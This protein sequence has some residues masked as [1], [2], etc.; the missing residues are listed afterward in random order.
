MR[1]ALITAALAATAIPAAP[2]Q[3]TTELICDSLPYWRAQYRTAQDEARRTFVADTIA[4]YEAICGEET[5]ATPSLNDIEPA[6]G[7]D[8]SPPRYPAI[9]AALPEDSYEVVETWAGWIYEDRVA[10]DDE[11]AWG[12]CLDKES[13]VAATIAAA[14]HS[15]RIENVTPTDFDYLLGAI[16]NLGGVRALVRSERLGRAIEGLDIARYARE[17]ATHPATMRHSLNRIDECLL[18]IGRQAAN[19]GWNP[20]S[21]VAPRYH[22]RVQYACE[23]GRWLE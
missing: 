2:A 21:F 19:G 22:T 8:T 4:R 5:A 9:V 3:T 18:R 20:S 16:P 1:I 15:I 12:Q 13:V 23:Q 14:C 10:P 7:G 6:A 11:G 17:T